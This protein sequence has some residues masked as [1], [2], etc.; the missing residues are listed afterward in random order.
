MFVFF[1]GFDV[2]VFVVVILVEDFGMIGDIMLVVVIFVDVCFMGVMD[3]CDVIIVV[4]FDLVEVFFCVFDL[5]VWIE[6]V[7]EDGQRVVVGIDLMWLEG[8]G[9][10]ML[11]VECFVLNIVQYL[12]GIVMMM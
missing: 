1:I 10:G 6:W 5:Y 3:S 7:V 8:L 4:G 2:F 12:L 11:I 9:W